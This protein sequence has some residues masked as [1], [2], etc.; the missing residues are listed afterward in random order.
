M[1]EA[2]QLRSRSMWSLGDYPAVAENWARMGPHVV[3]VAGVGPND[4]VLDVGCGHGNT[5]L[6]AARAGAKRVVGLDLTPEL[7]AVARQ[8]SAA[9]GLDIDWQE[10]DAEDLPF[11]D[12]AFDVVTSTL[13]VIFAPHP[14]QAAGELARVCRRGGRI[15]LTA[16]TNDSWSAAVGGSLAEFLPPPPADAPDL[17][18]WGEPDNVTA[19]LRGAGLEP[20]VTR[21][22]V[23]LRAPSAEAHI[24]SFQ[25]TAAPFIASLSAIDATGRGEEARQAMLDATSRIGRDTADGWE[26]DADYLLITATRS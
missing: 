4:E 11:A 16:W 21:E 14:E 2:Q 6:A 17:L 1:D 19:L 15:A 7:L 23:V 26:A 24:A 12:D 13:A 18:A 20:A 10:G 25:A 8:R 9:E 5:A 22:T 3:D